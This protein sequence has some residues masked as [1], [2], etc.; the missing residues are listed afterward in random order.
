MNTHCNVDVFWDIKVFCFP[1]SLHRII[2]K[3]VTDKL[4]I[5]YIQS[6]SVFLYHSTLRQQFYKNSGAF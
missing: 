2:C 3:T 1:N 5:A 4:K 6:S